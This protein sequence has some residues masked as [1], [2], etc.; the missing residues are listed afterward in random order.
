MQQLSHEIECFE[1]ARACR[2]V[3]LASL[4][5]DLH[6]VLSAKEGDSLIE[7]LT[8]AKSVRPMAGAMVCAPIIRLIPIVV[9][10]SF[11]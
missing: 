9:L 4:F 2:R 10:L 11:R 5:F 6:T 1:I 7:L 3:L 8:V